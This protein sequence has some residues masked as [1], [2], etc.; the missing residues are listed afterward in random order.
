[1]DINLE[2]FVWDEDQLSE[3][4]ALPVGLKSVAN[5]DGEKLY[6]SEKLNSS[7]LKAVSKNARVKPVMN[8]IAKL[9]DQNK[10]NPVFYEKGMIKFAAWKVFAP[11]NQK[12]TVAFYVLSLNKVYLI[13]SNAANIFTHIPNDMVSMLMV[14]ELMHMFAKTN[15]AQFKAI[16]MDT[17]IQYYSMV[18][19]IMFNTDPKKHHAIIKK[20]INHQIKH[21]DNV[22]TL[23]G[24][25]GSVFVKLKSILSEL[26][27]GSP[28]KKEQFE[29]RLNMYIYLGYL[30]RLDTEKWTREWKKFS[31]IVDI[32]KLA[33]KN[34]FNLPW[35]SSICTQE[36]L[37]PSEVA[38][39]CSEYPP[40]F[41][42]AH[43]S[44][45]KV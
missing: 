3:V 25:P 4:F 27:S 37:I 39:I 30:Y 31:S 5:L 43:Q 10:I 17:F 32:L 41:K 18:F 6:G 13:L 22:R 26:K 34:A 38:A 19:H 24:V 12:Y 8:K 15:E 44:I 23:K 36:I 45:A 40:F 11:L 1:M 16:W 2:N 29:E 42:K 14:H 9:I 20:A 35:T 7:F 28:L 21:F 33:Y